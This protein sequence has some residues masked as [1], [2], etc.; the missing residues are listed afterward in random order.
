MLKRYKDDIL[1][2]LTGTDEDIGWEW[3]HFQP[4]NAYFWV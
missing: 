3:T 4:I 2:E 1:R